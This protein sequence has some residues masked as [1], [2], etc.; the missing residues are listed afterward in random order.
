MAYEMIT[1]NEYVKELDNV[2]CLTAEENEIVANVE[3]YILN[4]QRSK[5]NASIVEALL[6]A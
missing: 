2:R 4:V 6:A 3:R 5:T 1:V